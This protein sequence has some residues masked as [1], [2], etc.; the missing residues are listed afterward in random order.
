M[1]PQK[2][3]KVRLGSP[4]GIVDHA[5]AICTF[6]QCYPDHARLIFYLFSKASPL[7]DQCLLLLGRRLKDIDQSYQVTLFGNK[8]IFSPLRY[9]SIG[10]PFLIIVIRQ[11][12]SLLASGPILERRREPTHS[13]PCCYCTRLRRESPQITP[14]H[15]PFHYHPVQTLLE[16]YF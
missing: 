5:G 12:V 13:L 7:I 6:V 8:H 15:I 3:V 10:G 4:L 14:K 2:G 9:C 1:P 11:V 16:S